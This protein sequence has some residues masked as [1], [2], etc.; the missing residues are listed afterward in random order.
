[1]KKVVIGLLFVALMATLSPA[2][3]SKLHVVTT[4]SILEDFVK[5]IGGERVKVDSLIPRG[6]DPHTW[7]PTPREARVVAQADLLVANGGGFD[8]WLVGLMKNAARPGIPLVIAS[9]GLATIGDAHEQDHHHNH[10]HHSHTGDPHFWLSVTNAIYYVEQITQVLVDVAPVHEPYFIKRSQAYVHEL[11]ELDQW[12]MDEVTKIPKN[13]R[14]I[15]TYHN[16]FSYLADR[17]GFEVAEFLVDNP[18]A[19][20]S[21]RDLARLVELLRGQTRPA[22]FTEPQLSG[23]NRYMQALSGE[24]RGTLYTLFSDSLTDEV[25]T[26]V[27]MM[28][29]NTRTLVEALQ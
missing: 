10:H 17:Y 12:I 16:A 25:P 29:Y 22:L 6:A 9:E 1:M 3:G 20:P 11:T 13:N 23:S 26:Y 19:E 5:Q 7:E 15:V 27:D 21:P 4:F 14:I 24:V 8:D 18:E 28:K 2:H